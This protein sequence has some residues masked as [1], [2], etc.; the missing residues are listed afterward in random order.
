MGYGRDE[1][2]EIEGWEE[3]AVGARVACWETCMGV[4]NAEDRCVG[5]DIG[6]VRTGLARGKK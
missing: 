2:E 5:G 4:A 1:K 3:M 6:S